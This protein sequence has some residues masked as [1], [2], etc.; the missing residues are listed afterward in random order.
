MNYLGEVSDYEIK[1]IFL[2]ISCL[3]P[4]CCLQ[5]LKNILHSH[6][7]LEIGFTKHLALIIIN[8]VRIYQN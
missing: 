8:I 5:D 2:H 1:R 6:I 7:P 4:V 3:T